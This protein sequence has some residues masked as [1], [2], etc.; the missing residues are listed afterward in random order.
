MAVSP[1]ALSS[2][3]SSCSS[4]SLFL[5][6]MFSSKSLSGDISVFLGS[7]RRI[8]GAVILEME[9][10]GLLVAICVCELQASLTSSLWAERRVECLLPLE[11]YF[12]L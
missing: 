10:K 2:L 3:S 5:R 9:W 11:V 4:L 12:A 1:L 8:S 6:I 7:R